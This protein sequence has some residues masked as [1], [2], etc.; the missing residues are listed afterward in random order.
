MSRLAHL[1]WPDVIDFYHSTL[2][3]LDQRLGTR[4]SSPTWICGSKSKKITLS[5][6]RN[7]NSVEVSDQ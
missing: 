4:S 5:T 2:P 6:A 7:V 3:C 1:K